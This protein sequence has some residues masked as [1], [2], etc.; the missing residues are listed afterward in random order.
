[1]PSYPGAVAT[2]SNPISSDA[3]NSVTVPHDIQHANAND[4]IEAI[5]TELG[6]LP[7]GTF[8]SVKLRLDD[9][10]TRISARVLSS[11]L[12]A[13]SGVATL[14]AG[15]KLVQ[16]VDASKV[17]SG[18]LATAQIPNLDA[19]KITT[20]AFNASRIPS[21]DGSILG[22][23]TVPVARIPNL[24]A[25]KITTG[26]IALARL[27]GTITGLTTVV[28]DITA[29]DAITPKIDGML[30]YVKAPESYWIWR[31]DNT[32]WRCLSHR[33]VATGNLDTNTTATYTD[34]TGFSVPVMA[35]VTYDV[36]CR[37]FVTNPSLSTADI[38]FGFTGPGGTLHMAHAGLDVGATSNIGSFRTVVDAADATSPYDGTADIGLVAGVNT[39][40]I[41]D[42][43]YICTTTGTLQLR[44]RQ[45]T[46]Q[47]TASRV[48][49][50]S[51]ME[52][53]SY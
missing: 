28:A 34:V 4:E 41:V 51:K 10:D 20:G 43:T 19:A 26:T 17:N 46:A 6:T 3:L 7:K 21:L 12:A 27:P 1:M 49:P 40:M 14:D 48:L 8:G 37:M 9:V 25:S 32:T 22:T 11:S 53:R 2:L 39:W 36:T 31:A 47:A 50:G 30:V 16:N 23:G 35:G 38:R 24:D 5:E 18:V 45:G 33:V 52:T 42:A 15:S 13:A 29:R 44:F